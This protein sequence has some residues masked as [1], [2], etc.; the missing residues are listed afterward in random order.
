MIYL[1]PTLHLHISHFSEN[2][3]LHVCILPSLCLT[4]N[5]FFLLKTCTLPFFFSLTSY[6]CKITLTTKE[7]LHVWRVVN[8]TCCWF[9][10]YVEKEF[11][12]S[13]G[14]LSYLLYIKHQEN[15]FVTAQ[16]K[17]FSVAILWL[18]EDVMHIFSR[19][20]EKKQEFLV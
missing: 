7:C 8:I 6:R 10:Y 4:H 19:I 15:C 12:G 3:I 5:Q 1:L 13:R 2:I 11:S 9:E 20:K 16:G 14:T 18:T 17:Q